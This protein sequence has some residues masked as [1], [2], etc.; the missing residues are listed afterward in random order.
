MEEVLNVTDSSLWK[1]AGSGGKFESVFGTA[2]QPCTLYLTFSS[3][4]QAAIEAGTL[5]VGDRETTR[6]H[7]EAHGR[8]WEVRSARVR[9]SSQV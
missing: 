8:L 9:R 2:E 1:V 4:V 3:D 6:A 7:D 5:M